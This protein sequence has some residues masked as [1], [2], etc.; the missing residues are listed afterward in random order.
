MIDAQIK[1]FPLLSLAMLSVDFKNNMILWPNILQWT[2]PNFPP[3]SVF[4]DIFHVLKCVFLIFHNFQ[5]SRHIPDPT[6]SGRC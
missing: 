1:S 3:F 5:F 2:F 6:V 4:L